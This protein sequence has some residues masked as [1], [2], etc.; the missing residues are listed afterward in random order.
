MSSK[1][2]HIGLLYIEENK[3]IAREGDLFVGFDE[4]KRKKFQVYN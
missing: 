2:K 1:I 3:V 4:Q